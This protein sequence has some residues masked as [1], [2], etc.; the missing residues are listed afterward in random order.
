VEQRKK[1]GGPA[2]CRGSRA[3]RRRLQQVRLLFRGGDLTTDGSGLGVGVPSSGC[4]GFAVATHGTPP[5][6]ASP[7][8]RT[9]AQRLRD[10]LHGACALRSAFSTPPIF[11]SSSGLRRGKKDNPKGLLD[12]GGGGFWGGNPQGWRGTGRGLVGAVS[13]RAA[14]RVSRH[15]S[16]RLGSLGVR[17]PSHAAASGGRGRAQRG[18]RR[19]LSRR[20]CVTVGKRNRG[21]GKGGDEADRGSHM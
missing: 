14:P 1:T 18:A 15:G 10:G 4:S 13:Y 20:P 8:G 5:Q 12:R 19:S 9:T 3:A 17:A 21:K 16:G 11:P 7:A 6:A 2:C